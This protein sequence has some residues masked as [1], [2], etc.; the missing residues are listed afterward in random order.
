MHWPRDPYI[1]VLLPVYNGGAY[2]HP[3]IDSVLAQTLA[4]FECLVVDDGSSD[5]SAAVAAAYARRDP[6]VRLIRM[7][8]RRGLVAALNTALAVAR[9]PLLAR[10]D[11]D[12]VSLPGRLARQAAE[13][14]REPAL[15]FVSSRVAYQP[16][17]PGTGGL[18][19]YVEWQNSLLTPAEIRRDLFVESPVVH[20][21]VLM[22]RR[23]VEA[24]G[25][26]RDVGW[27]EDYDLWM[28]LLLGGGVAAK[29]PETLLVWRDRRDRLSRCGDAYRL[30]SFRRLKLH[31]LAKA[32]LRPGESVQVCGA[33]PTGRW[34]TRE[35]VRAGYGVSR[36]IEIDPRRA[37]HRYRGVPIMA[38]SGL[39]AGSERLVSAVASWAARERI[40]AHLRG[41][42]LLEVRDFVAVA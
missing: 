36:I 17:G 6:R 40:R 2:L 32:W 39:R 13:L 27:P 20:P 26:Y 5:G 18:R 38:P 37:G 42:G 25:G 16:E 15:A 23:V 12:D 3:A 34:W 4:D 11:A 24:A 41:Q 21:T 14:E 7:D 19:R 1:S 30:S 10:M 33:G 28:R 29:V 9:G 35:L 22:R 8:G 31:Y